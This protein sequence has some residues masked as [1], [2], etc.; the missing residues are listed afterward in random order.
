MLKLINTRS[1]RVFE[2]YFNNELV[3][4]KFKERPVKKKRKK[5]DKIV[6]LVKIANIANIAN[7][8]LLEND[9]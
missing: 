3:F 9:R 6:C 5:G 8:I 4:L 2:T 1:V 7:I